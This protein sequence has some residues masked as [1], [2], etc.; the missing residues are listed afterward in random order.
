A[1]G[2][3]VSARALYER[4]ARLLLVELVSPRSL[5]GKNTVEA[6]QSGLLFGHASMIDGMVE[7]ISKEL[8]APTVV[9][10]GGLA[11]TVME[12]CNTIDHLEP[13]LTLE[14][15]RIVFDRNTERP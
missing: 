1:P 4:T 3:Q 13:W 7:R 12:E 15:L 5:I 10:T 6:L 9:A 14:G 8:G 11:S 2:I